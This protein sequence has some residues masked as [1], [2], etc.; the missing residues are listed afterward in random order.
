M[1]SEPAALRAARLHAQH[2]ALRVTARGGVFT[3]SERYGA[4]KKLGTYRLVATLRR[5]IWHHHRIIEAELAAG[6]GR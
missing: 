1:K 2:I 3:L 6:K 4:K 5:G